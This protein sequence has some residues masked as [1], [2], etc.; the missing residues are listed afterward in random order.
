MPVRTQRWVGVG[1]ATL[2]A[3]AVATALLTPAT[4]RTSLDPDAATPGGSR[5][6]AEMLREQGVSV[7]R[8]TDAQRALSV[9]DKTTLIVA[10]PELLPPGDITLLEQLRSDVVLLGPVFAPDGYLDV[11]PAARASLADRDP[12]CLLDAALRAGDARTGGTTFD[13][14]GSSARS[15]STAQCFGTDGR[16]TLVQTATDAGAV[17]TIMGSADFM[18]NEWL[19]EAGNAAL[20]MN[21]AGRNPALVWWL[22]TPQYTGQQSL[23]SLLPDGVWPLLGA[24]MVVVLMTAAWRAR[25]LGPVTVESLPVTVRA[26][27]TTEGR[28]RIYQRHGTRGQAAEHLRTETVDTLR[29]HL[30]LPAPASHEAITQAVATSTGRRPDEVQ[31]ILYGPP[32]EG[33]PA[34]VSLGRQLS[35]LEQEVR[36]A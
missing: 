6:L 4:G 34:L 36:H 5:A 8:T 30:G 7:E 16:P 25:R 3:L 19:D 21:L 27:E 17:H 20:A 13:V 1:L 29:L 32:P 26:S 14:A 11:T 24:I 2:L 31:Q 15:A 18:T 28:A 33:D 10:Y 12:E 23:T 35:A 22:P 9:D